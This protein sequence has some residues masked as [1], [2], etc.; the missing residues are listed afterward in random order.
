M[1]APGKEHWKALEHLLG[2]LKH[3]YRPMK[4]HAPKEL[5]AVAMF[6]GDWATDKNDQKSM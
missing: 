5:R 1:T 4:F 6:D 2:Y 3:H